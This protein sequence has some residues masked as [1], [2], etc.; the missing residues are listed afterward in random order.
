MDL[1]K[2]IGPDALINQF[3]INCFDPNTAKGQQNINLT[4]D[5]QD[6]VFNEL[7]CKSFWRFK[8]INM[9]FSPLLLINK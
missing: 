3:T 2:I 6:L 8:K 7:T 4:N 5:L 9:L 1:L